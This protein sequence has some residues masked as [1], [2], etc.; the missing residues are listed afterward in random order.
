MKHES[1]IIKQVKTYFMRRKNAAEA[2]D[3]EREIERDA[4][5]YEAVEGFENLHVSEIQQALDELELRVHSKAKASIFEGI[6]WRVAATVL[7]VIVGGATLIT[8]GINQFGEQSLAKS[9]EGN[10]AYQPRTEEMEYTAI[11]D[12]MN[13]INF[14]IAADTKETAWAQQ[15]NQDQEEP[16]VAVEEEKRDDNRLKSELEKDKKSIQKPAATADSYAFEDTAEENTKLKEAMSPEFVI[17]EEVQQNVQYSS[18]QTISADEVSR[19]PSNNYK[20]VEKSAGKNLDVTPKPAAP[21]VGNSAYKTYVANNLQKTEEMVS[22][23]VTLSFEF[24]KNGQ[25][26]KATVVKSLCEA[27]DQEAIRLIENG[28]VWNVE[29]RKERATYTIT[30]P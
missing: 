26:K 4:F 27:C 3:F 11:P 20:S 18:P 25:P 30:I 14:D 5:L 12:S 1:E 24:D 10:N 9:E 28:P 2:Y 6:N 7:A 16:A 8:I 23:S 13:I 19:I 15:E 17:S 29:D 21:S 22:G